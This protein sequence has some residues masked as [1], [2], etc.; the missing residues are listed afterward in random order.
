MSKRSDT[1][2]AQVA[3]FD[4]VMTAID[5]GRDMRAFVGGALKAAV[6]ERDAALES[7][8]LVRD[9]FFGESERMAEVYPVGTAY[10]NR[11]AAAL[12]AKEHD[13]VAA[14]IAAAE[15]LGKEPHAYHASFVGGV[16]GC[17]YCGRPEDEHDEQPLELHG[18]WPEPEHQYPH[19]GYFC[20]EQDCLGY[21]NRPENRPALLAAV[22]EPF[23]DAISVRANLAF[24]LWPPT[25]KGE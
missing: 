3:A 4:M 24:G 23:S 18:I 7:E 16:E 17:Y 21:V 11:I 12:D 1:L 13:P 14:A 2:A 25:G 9:G 22:A 19:S 5:E 20:A 8:R 15:P 10:A 6:R